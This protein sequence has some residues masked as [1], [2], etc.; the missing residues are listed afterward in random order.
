VP[1]KHK[2]PSRRKL[3]ADGRLCYDGR[4]VGMLAAPVE[5]QGKRAE[6]SPLAV[7]L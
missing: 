1:G 3:T 5:P 2:R 6:A 7:L 4:T